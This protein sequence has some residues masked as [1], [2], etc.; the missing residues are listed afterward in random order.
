MGSKARPVKIWRGGK[1]KHTH[2]HTQEKSARVRGAASFFVCCCWRRGRQWC[3]VRRNKQGEGG[4]GGGEQGVVP[5]NMPT[6]PQAGV[7][8]GD[9]SQ[10]AVCARSAGGSSSGGALACFGG[11]E[12]MSDANPVPPPVRLGLGLGGSRPARQGRGRGGKRQ[13]GGRGAGRHINQRF[14]A[15]KEKGVDERGGNPK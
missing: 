3:G 9:H 15:K 5:H 13:K 12:R 11:W 14:A 1:T 10:N 7:G 6:K 8:G 4:T 2:T